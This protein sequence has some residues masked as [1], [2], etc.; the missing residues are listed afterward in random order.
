MGELIAGQTMIMTWAYS[1]GTISLN[2]D[3][4]TFGWSTTANMEDIS[5]GADTQ[6]GRM[7]TLIDAHADVTLVQQTAGTALIAALA[8]TTAGTLTVQ[9]EGT[10]AGKRTI[11]LPCYCDGAQY[12]IPYANVAV[13]TCG[14]TPSSVLGLW[15]DA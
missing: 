13:I 12:D 3:Y 15:T 5:A 4:R 10:A 11:T 8:A 1:G 2:A 9:P 14:F 7:P 6:V